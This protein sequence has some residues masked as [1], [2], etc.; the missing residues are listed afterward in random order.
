MNE[1]WIKLYRQ[2]TDSELWQTEPFTKAQAWI[3]LL[4]SAT[5]K[6]QTVFIH[7]VEINL[8]PGE[9]CRSQLTLSKRW[10]WHR[11]TVKKYL[12]WL[13]SREMIH[14]KNTKITTIISVINWDKYQNEISFTEAS[15][16]QKNVQ[17][18]NVEIES[19]TQKIGHIYEQSVQQSVQQNVQQL[20]HKQECKE[21]KED[22]HS[23]SSNDDT[24]RVNLVKEFEQ[25]WLNEYQKRFGEK[26]VLDYGKDRKLIKELLKIFT[27]DKLK[28]KATIFM[29]TDDDNFLKKTG[30]TIGVFKTRINSLSEKEAKPNRVNGVKL[31][32]TEAQ[33]YYAEH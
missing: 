18:K 9:L 2:I 7:G 19:E 20:R 1:G 5:H 16:Y 11:Q 23:V 30:H 27:L 3:D 17:Q 8:K 32:L 12:L 28:R 21:C 25:W 15:N 24:H 13:Q 22:T 31:E 6:P 4:L 14:F 26:Y 10:K 29:E 33:K